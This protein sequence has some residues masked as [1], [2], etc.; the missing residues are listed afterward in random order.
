[1]ALHIAR[2][3]YPVLT[4]GPGKR[5]GI[6]TAGCPR[7]CPGCISP[8][9]QDTENGRTMTPGQVLGLLRSLGEKPEGITISGGEPFLDPHALLELLKGLREITE[10]ILLFTGFR[11]EQLEKDPICAAAAAMCAVIVDGPYE[12]EKNTGVGL[13]GS[14]NQNIIVN[15]FAERY[16]GAEAW[17]RQLQLVT[18]GGNLLSLGIPGGGNHAQPG[19]NTGP[20]PAGQ[21][22]YRRNPD[23]GGA[24]TGG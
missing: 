19:Q 3:Y 11:M 21:T 7:A 22:E 9:L 16:A 18:Y 12:R 4:L 5:L 2:M 13:R 10:D 20:I 6:W 1:M 23:A 14:D 24:G 15:R 8:E 17:D